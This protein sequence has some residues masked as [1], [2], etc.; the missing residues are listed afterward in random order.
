[1]LPRS[2]LKTLGL[3]RVR[4]ENSHT[5]L[6]FPQLGHGTAP[7]EGKTGAGRISAQPSPTCWARHRRGTN[8]KTTKSRRAGTPVCPPEGPAPS[9]GGFVSSKPPGKL[10]ILGMLAWGLQ[11][12]PGG[13]GGKRQ[14]QLL[15]QRRESAAS[16]RGST[17]QQ[18]HFYSLSSF[19]P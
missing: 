13:G 15:F 14:F 3:G 11:P 19:T 12:A 5:G 9:S 4:A 18:W 2:A 1:M 17:E 7:K 16:R 8:P 6:G 10:L